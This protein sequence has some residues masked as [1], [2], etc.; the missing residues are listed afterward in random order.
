[1]LYRARGQRAEGLLEHRR[2]HRGR[3]A[4]HHRRARN[5][6]RRV[7]EAREGRRG[8]RPGALMLD[9]AII[10]AGPVG[11]AVAALCAQAGLEIAIFEARTEPGNDAR[12]L[13]LSHASRALLGEAG[14][15]SG[16]AATAIE[17]IH[18]SQKGGPGRTLI[19][20]SE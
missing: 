17:S 16:D 3:C 13:A 1:M 12:T 4:R 5:P 2:S 15:W 6:H 14:A 19:R 20:A 11:A 18:I 7:S 8:G 10:G 9:V